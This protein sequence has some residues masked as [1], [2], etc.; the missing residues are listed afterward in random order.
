MSIQ[1]EQAINLRNVMDWLGRRSLKFDPD[2][3][4][5]E[6]AAYLQDVEDTG[7]PDTLSGGAEEFFRDGLGHTVAAV[8]NGEV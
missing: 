6:A 7:L 2:P 1:Q 8:N 5:G 3:R 4:A